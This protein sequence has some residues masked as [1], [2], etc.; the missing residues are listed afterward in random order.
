M[1]S[2][3]SLGNSNFFKNFPDIFSDTGAV[4]F[5]LQAML[6]HP[7]NIEQTQLLSIKRCMCWKWN[8]SCEDRNWT[9]LIYPW[10]IHTTCVFFVQARHLYNHTELLTIKSGLSQTPAFLH[11]TRS[12]HT[13]LI[14]S[15]CSTKVCSQPCGIRDLPLYMSTLPKPTPGNEDANS[16]AC[17]CATTLAAVFTIRHVTAEPGMNLLNN[18][19]YLIGA[20]Y[21]A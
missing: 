3:S 15:W 8:C 18:Y 16:A 12:P 6:F 7:L 21:F 10:E 17:R 14:N 11:P 19:L 20:G 5:K 9:A 13:A 4:A 2:A 1:N